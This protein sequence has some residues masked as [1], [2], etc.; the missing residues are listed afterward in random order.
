MLQGDGT[1]DYAEGSTAC[2]AAYRSRAGPKG[3]RYAN[4]ASAIKTGNASD[5]NRGCQ[6]KMPDVSDPFAVLTARKAKPPR[7]LKTQTDTRM[8]VTNSHA[9][10]S[11]VNQD[12]GG[13]PKNVFATPPS[14]YSSR[15]M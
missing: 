14:S 8:K 9:R 5:I 13:G 12:G 11:H 2:P 7:S 1:E 3:A 10:V 6:L 15:A 4:T